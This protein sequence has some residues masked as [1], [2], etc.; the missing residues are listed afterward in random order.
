M[1]HGT[2]TS[3]VS[4]LSG[5]MCASLRKTADKI[6]AEEYQKD[7]Q[8][9]RGLKDA[10]PKNK[11]SKP[12]FTDNQILEMRRLHEYEG[13]SRSELCK[14]FDMDYHAAMRITDY[15]TRGKLVPKNG[16]SYI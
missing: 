5:I 2:Q 6:L 3:L 4:G 15:I 1:K 7:L 8:K 9:R 16:P 12:K 14:M 11:G 10:A 13:V